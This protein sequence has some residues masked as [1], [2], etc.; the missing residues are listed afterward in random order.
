V[1]KKRI[2]KKQTEFRAPSES[3]EAL[4]IKALNAKLEAAL[5]DLKDTLNYDAKYLDAEPSGTSSSFSSDF[6]GVD[7]HL[8]RATL[9]ALYE[10][11][12]W[13]YTAVTEIAKTIASLPL[14]LERRVA[15]KKTVKNPVT[16]NDE[17][18]NQVVWD[19]ASGEPLFKCFETPNSFTTRAEWLMLLVIDL[20]TAGEFY[21]YLDSDIDLSVLAPPNDD[22][23]KNDPFSRLQRAV[24]DAG[25]I[26]GMY[27]IPPPMI[28]PVPDQ[29]AGRGYISGY[30][31]E[32]DKGVFAFNF[33]EII[34]VKLPNPNDPYR[35]LSP[36]VAAFKPVLLDR[37]ST[38]HM[39][40]FYKT[41][42]RLGGVIET[43][44]NLNKE[45]LSRFQRTFEA[46]FT[47][48]KNHH[49]TL[50]LPPGMKYTTIEQNP[51]ETALLDF[52]KYN[53]E[54]ILSVYH[55]PPIKVGIL[56]NANYA[57]A[58]VQLQIFFT[59]TI[60]PLLRFIED[61][62]NNKASLMPKNGGYRIK[63]DLSDV[64]VLKEDFLA[65]ATMAAAMIKAG[66]TINEVRKLVWRE[67]PIEK[68]DKQF[69]VAEIEKLES[70]NSSGPILGLAAPAPDALKDDSG[71]APLT[72][73]G[74]PA[75][76]HTDIAG[77]GPKKPQE[78]TKCDCAT[79]CNCGPSCDC[80]PSCE[81]CKPPSG[82]APSTNEMLATF[83]SDALSKLNPLESIPPE[84]IAELVTIFNEQHGLAS[85]AKETSP[86]TAAMPEADSAPT[87]ADIEHSPKNYAN[88]Y[89][90]DQVVEHWKSFVSKAEPLIAKRKGAVVKFFKATQREVLNRFGANIKSFGIFKSRDSDDISEILNEHGFSDIVKEYIK[91]IDVAL[92]EAYTTGYAETLSGF[93]FKPPSEA[94][95]EWLKKYGADEVKNILDTTRDQLREVLTEAF[96]EG[97]SV[98]EVSSRIKDKF[99]EMENGRAETIAR[100]ETLSAVSAGQEQKAQDWQK[101][102]PDKTLLKMWVSAQDERVRDSHQELDGEVVELSADFSN[103]LQYPREAGG[104]PS[105][106]INC[107]CARIT[108]AEEDAAAIDSTLPPKEST[109]EE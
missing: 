104:D 68:G 8:D 3:K 40:R 30:A 84:F 35:G 90:K 14:K 77:P 59:D 17:V 83:I 7:Q 99:G 87:Q 64:E 25:D 78:E 28:K 72:T 23:P 101:E 105:E 70:Q 71:A 20:L 34:H 57:N 19:D 108:Y 96:E 41:G 63:F 73:G 80:G 1:S 16:G 79:K 12:T 32:S 74:Q 15:V 33:A 11:E 27:R 82:K 58:R 10:S 93:V 76:I 2:A 75:L 38:E 22:E 18:I 61:G 36:L 31:M 109:E 26:K 9:Q 24:T 81:C 6:S 91:E 98:S 86:E 102:F 60:K 85:A 107:R 48:R 66:L 13:V 46:N 103:G 62:Y 97:V 94:A 49:R 55:V 45:Q 89:S 29:S 106:V 37:F 88:G 47:G 92:H 4:E 5:G 51:G 39:V 44:K 69:N 42:A 65:M 53:R 21:I 52:C 50:I 56:D 54:S 95:A 100:T 67:D 43:D